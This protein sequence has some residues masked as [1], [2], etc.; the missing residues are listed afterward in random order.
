MGV[1]AGEGARGGSGLRHVERS[2][3]EGAG[4]YNRGLDSG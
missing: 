4:A 1:A 2:P 3:G